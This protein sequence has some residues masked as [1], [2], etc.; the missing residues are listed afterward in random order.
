[1]SFR[2]FLIGL[3]EVAIFFPGLGLGVNERGEAQVSAFVSIEIETGPTLKHRITLKYLTKG[4][5]VSV[6]IS[7]KARTPF[8]RRITDA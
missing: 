4:S 8:L 1:V 2:Y 7:L 5:C 3:V 6:E